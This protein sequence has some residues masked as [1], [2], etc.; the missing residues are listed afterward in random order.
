MKRLVAVMLFSALAACGHSI[1]DSCHTNVDCATDGTRFCDISSPSGY[2]SI[3]GCDITTCPSEAICVRFLTPLL[4]K[5]CNGDQLMDGF[6]PDS[7]KCSLDQ[8]CVCNN[9]IQPSGHCSAWYCAPEA[10][11]R[12]W[13]MKGCSADTDCRAGYRCAFTA[14]Y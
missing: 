9:I 5:S 3:D 13:C 8:R 11:E 2:C 4:D 14:E 6:N 12:R 7:S 1:G 10:S